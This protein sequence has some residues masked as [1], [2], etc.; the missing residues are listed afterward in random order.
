ME[1]L[2]R[3]DFDDHRIFDQQVDSVA[4]IEY[5]ATVS[6]GKRFLAL[7]REPPGE[8]FVREKSLIRRFQ[9]PGTEFFVD[10]NRG[11]DDSIGQRIQTRLLGHARR[12]LQFTWQCAS[13]ERSRV[14][15]RT[16]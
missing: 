8:Q 16:R 12:A 11:G 9:Q 14:L 4:E 5:L 2:N 6:Y 13:R 3:L 10:G 7:D 1:S 15:S